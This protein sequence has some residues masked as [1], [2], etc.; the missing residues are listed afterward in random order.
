MQGPHN[1]LIPK[2]VGPG[3]HRTWRRSQ[4]LLANKW[5]TLL[6]M[7]EFTSHWLATD[8][9]H[10]TMPSVTQ[11]CPIARHDVCSVAVFSSSSEE[12]V[13]QVGPS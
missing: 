11:P 3:S 5:N 8:D 2:R 13:E 9:L 4:M 6:A 12:N 1:A 7:G 10:Q